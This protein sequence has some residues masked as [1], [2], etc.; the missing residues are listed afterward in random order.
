MRRRPVGG[1]CMSVDDIEDWTKQPTFGGML[2]RNQG[3]SAVIKITGM[4]DAGNGEA[5]ATTVK[6]AFQLGYF[7]VCA[8]DDGQP[9]PVRVASMLPLLAMRLEG[10]G[11]TLFATWGEFAVGIYHHWQEAAPLTTYVLPPQ[12]VH[13][14]LK[15]MKDTAHVVPA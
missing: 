1:F 14:N 10:R 12:L 7:R 9:D 3:K 8:M 11:I 6:E 4:R 15:S 5:D 13:A 2:T